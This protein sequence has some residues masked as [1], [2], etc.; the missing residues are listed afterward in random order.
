[1]PLLIL[2]SLAFAFQPTCKTKFEYW[3]SDEQLQWQ[4][5]LVDCETWGGSL[6]TLTEEKQEYFLS[7]LISNKEKYWIGM[8]TAK[9]PGFWIDLKPVTY[10]HFKQDLIPRGPDSNCVTIMKEQQSRKK[11]KKM[12][13]A[14]RLN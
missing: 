12:S 11:Q 3:V 2:I 9:K 14:V 10:S 6:V 5:A 1:M 13:S 8:N 7:G 4:E